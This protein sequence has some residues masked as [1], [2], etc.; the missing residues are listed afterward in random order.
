[1]ERGSFLRNSRGRVQVYLGFC[2]LESWTSGCKISIPI[3]PEAS[4]WKLLDMSPD[5]S[6]ISRDGVREAKPNFIPRQSVSLGPGF[7]LGSIGSVTLIRY[8]AYL[9]SP[10]SEEGANFAVL[11]TAQLGL[12]LSCRPPLS[13]LLR[14]CR[15]RTANTQ[16]FQTRFRATYRQFRLIHG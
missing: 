10:F 14:D 5:W 6:E 3:Y 2:V 4:K 16:G 8:A 12:A 11:D 13:V 1:M 7:K 15:V 9:M